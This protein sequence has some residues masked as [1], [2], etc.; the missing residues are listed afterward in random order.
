MARG[1]A[2][3]SL[4]GRREDGAKL[5]PGRYDV[6]LAVKQLPSFK[7]R[8]R[9]RTTEH[10]ERPDRGRGRGRGVESGIGVE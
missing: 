6:S 4:A 5:R 2:C 10:V 9:C 1:L 7:E 3:R 8:G